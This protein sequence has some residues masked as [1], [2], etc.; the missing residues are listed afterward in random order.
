V[1]ASANN[2]YVAWVP[3]SGKG[4]A[5]RRTVNG[6][7]AWKAQQ[8]IT[9]SNVNYVGP[10]ASASGATVL[11][12]YNLSTGAADVARSTNSGAAFNSSTVSPAASNAKARDVTIVGAQ[13]RVSL[14]DDAANVW[15]RKSSNGGGVWAAKSAAAPYGDTPN[16]SVGNGKTVVVFNITSE[17]S[18]DVYSVHD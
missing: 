13:A 7:T 9:N 5:V 14:S 2:A 6:G 16:V 11:I 10:S 8:T 18:S 12:S 17:F 3:G 15:V 1:A 4:V